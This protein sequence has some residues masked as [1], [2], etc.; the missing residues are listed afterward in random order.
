MKLYLVIGENVP[1]EWGICGLFKDETKAWSCPLWKFRDR[2]VVEIET[3][4][5]EGDSG[6]QY[7]PLVSEFPYAAQNRSRMLRLEERREK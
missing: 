5:D 3:D 4:F 7:L 2:K 1:A 6:A